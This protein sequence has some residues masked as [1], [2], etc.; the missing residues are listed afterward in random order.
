MRERGQKERGGERERGGRKREG[1]KREGEKE[2]RGERERGEKERGG[3][4]EEGERGG[5]VPLG[6][7]HVF[8]LTVYLD[9]MSNIPASISI[10]ILLK[11]KLHILAGLRQKYSETIRETNEGADRHE[12]S[13]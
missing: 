13:I 1:R 4:R 6:S 7:K 12:E 10:F 3:K 2:R 5:G 8:Q 11:K 9:R